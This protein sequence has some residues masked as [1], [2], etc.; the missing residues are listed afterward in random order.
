MNISS[1][2]QFMFACDVA[3]KWVAARTIGTVCSS[4]SSCKFLKL[5]VPQFL[6]L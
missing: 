1:A 6:Y 5:P 3:E 2:T 4:G